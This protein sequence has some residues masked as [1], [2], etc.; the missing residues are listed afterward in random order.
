MI[1][2]RAVKVAAPS[3]SE[4]LSDLINIIIAKAEVPD[5]WK[6]GQITPL[7]KKD[8][9]L[10]KAN[11]R[12][13]TVLPAFDK[14]FERIVHTQMSSYFD[15]IFHDFMFAYR[16]FHGCS[17]ALLTLTEEWKEKLD[18]NHV[19]GAASLDLSKAFDCI[20]HD[21]MLEK[22]RFYGLGERS[23][24]LLQSYL[25]H[26]YQ[27]VK[28]GNSFSSWK[29]VRSGVPQ[30]SILGPLLFNIYMNDLAYAINESRLLSFA[31]DT[32][33]YASNECP[34]VV[35]NLLN[36]DLFNASSWFK[37]NGMLAN[38]TK[39]NAIVLG[40]ANQRN[41]SIE[42]GDKQIPV[43]KEIKLLGITLDEKLKFDAHIAEICRKVGRQINALSRLKNILPCK[44]KEALYRAFI[45]PY[46]SYCSQVWYHCGRRNIEKLERT[47]ARALRFV[48]NDR[49]SSYEALLGRIG[50]LSTLENRRTQDMLLT[51]NNIIQGK[52]PPSFNNLI[53]E[54]RTAYNLRGNFNLSIPKVN[55]TRYGLKSWRYAAAKQWNTL[56]RDIRSIAGSKDFSKKIRQTDFHV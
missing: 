55:T 38:P 52:A 37:Q 17:A 10:D 48:Y 1:P 26:R 40:N 34:R 6:Y 8:S 25:S 9:V 42:C 22:L 30:G 32:N 47:N 12:P 46:F 19:I 27:R 50:S 7:H 41:I 24:S 44:T 20:P 3:V 13:V 56:P 29:I 33:L 2:P 14:V 54:K 16:K 11:F 39:Y 28:L 36:Q 4:P 5:R 45:S 49:I 31:D 53:T 23:W 15:S 21:L 51:V 18:Q 43:S 35:E